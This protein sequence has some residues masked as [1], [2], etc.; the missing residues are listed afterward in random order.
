MG[1]SGFLGY[2]SKDNNWFIFKEY[3]LWKK[4][5]ATKSLKVSSALSFRLS[6]RL[7]LCLSC[8]TFS[9]L[10]YYSQLWKFVTDTFSLVSWDCSQSAQAFR[11]PSHF[12]IDFKAV[13]LQLGQFFPNLEPIIFWLSFSLFRAFSTCN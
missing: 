6:F 4:F 10:R 13:F 8:W 5:R 2:G 12:C 7:L 9:Y 3:K 1:E 11:F